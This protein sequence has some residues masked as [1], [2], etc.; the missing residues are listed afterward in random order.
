MQVGL[1]QRENRKETW[2]PEANWKG[3]CVPALGRPNSGLG[4]RKAIE[5]KL[6]PYLMEKQFGA[7]L[8]TGN[9]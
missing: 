5:G 6:F 7:W 2:A 9:H 8:G 4:A 1:L 3:S